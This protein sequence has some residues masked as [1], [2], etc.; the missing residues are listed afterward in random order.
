MSIE[1]SADRQGYMDTFGTTC[2]VDG[3]TITA[4]W[5]K[6]YLEDLGVATAVP[7]IM[8][9]TT[10]IPNIAYGQSVVVSS[11]SFTGTVREIH[12]DGV[13]LTILYLQES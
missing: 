8:C 4:I 7:Q 1:S 11:A 2:V 5:D 3:E 6:P 13:G 9:V 12:P 10:D